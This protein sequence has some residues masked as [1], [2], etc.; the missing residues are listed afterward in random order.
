M[1]LMTET[2]SVI[3]WG[4]CWAVTSKMTDIIRVVNILAELMSPS[5]MRKV[6]RME[7]RIRGVV[8]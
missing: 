2:S 1:E 4:S 3:A 7:V 8:R 5:K 6:K